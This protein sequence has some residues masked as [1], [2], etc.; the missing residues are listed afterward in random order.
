[1]KPVSSVRRKESHFTFAMPFYPEIKLEFL[2]HRRLWRVLGEFQPDFIH[3]TTEGPLGWAAR[4]VLSPPQ[5]LLLNSVPCRDFPEY[6]A[7]RTPRV[8]S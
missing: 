2:A 4:R 8:L 1:M 6:L 3:I 7:A 5:P